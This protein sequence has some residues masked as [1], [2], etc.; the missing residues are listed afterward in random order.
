MEGGS[1]QW[2]YLMGPKAAENEGYREGYSSNHKQTGIDMSRLTKG[3]L[4]W[5]TQSLIHIVLET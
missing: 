1:R 2:R 5:F 3:A 4:N